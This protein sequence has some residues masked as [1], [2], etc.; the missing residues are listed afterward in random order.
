MRNEIEKFHHTIGVL[1]KAYLNNTLE[2]GHDCACA[3]GNLVADACGYSGIEWEAAWFD[4]YVCKVKWEDSLALAKE[5][6]ESTGYS[7]KEII[8]IEKAFE[9]AEWARDE[10]GWIDDEASMFNSLVAVVDVLA[11]IH[12]IDLSTLEETKK[13]FVKEN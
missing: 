5:Q 3:V 7:V 2:R 9:K 10:K 4:V 11:E 1:V 12:G 6:I 13:L 8:K